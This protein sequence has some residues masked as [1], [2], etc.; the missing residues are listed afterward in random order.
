MLLGTLGVPQPAK[1]EGAE[2]TGLG[3]GT[4]QCPKALDQH[5]GDSVLGAE[6]GQE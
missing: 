3:D 6:L 4:G 5:P 1:R 2:P